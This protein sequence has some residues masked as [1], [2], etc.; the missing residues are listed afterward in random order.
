[1]LWVLSKIGEYLGLVEG[2][3]SLD[4]DTIAAILDEDDPL[5]QYDDEQPSDNKLPENPNGVVCEQRVGCVTELSD[6]FGYIK[7]VDDDNSRLY[8][9]RKDDCPANLQVGS[10][11]LF[12]GYKLS[13]DSEWIV[14]KIL[15]LENETWDRK[16]NCEE[17]EVPLNQTAVKWV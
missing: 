17:E 16:D 1:M 2:E 7:P 15:S 9:D 8:F 5:P 6:T 10:H 11:V 13:E 3:P 4:Y 14:R 12:L